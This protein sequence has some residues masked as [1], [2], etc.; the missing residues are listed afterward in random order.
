MKH[1]R[2]YGHVALSIDTKQWYQQ[3][4]H[5]LTT[6]IMTLA[7]AA[8]EKVTTV[9]TLYKANVLITIAPHQDKNSGCTVIC[10]VHV[11]PDLTLR[12]HITLFQLSA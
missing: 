8:M 10:V 11:C 2:L 12:L 1:K 6:Q 9:G 5:R 3:Q 4:R 7:L